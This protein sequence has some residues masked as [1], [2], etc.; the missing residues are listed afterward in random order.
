AMTRTLVMDNGAHAIKAGYADDS[1]S[2]RTI[3]NSI[4][5]GRGDRRSFVGD[6]LE[7]CK[8]YSGLYF[9]LP[10]ERGYLT[11]WDVE[12]DVW[13]RVFS[14]QVLKCVPS[15]V[16]LMITEPCFNPPNIQQTYDEMVFE[17]YGFE[18]YHRSIAP[19]LC[20][21]ANVSEENPPSECMIV[22][23]SGY[24]FTHIV[25]FC[26]GKPIQ[27]AIKRINLGGKLLTNHLKE[28]VS[29][30]Y[31]NMM[32]E[33]YLMNEIKEQC[34]YVTQNISVDFS[35]SK[36]QTPENSILQRYVLPDFSTK[37][38]KMQASQYDIRPH[39]QDSN[40]APLSED[41]QVL[42]MNNERFTIPEI[43]FHPSDIGI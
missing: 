22:V 8:D 28:V 18:A 40:D 37:K 39:N 6:Q 4:T 36:S 41:D 1:E 10:F 20:Q 25:P 30:R 12:K 43:L 23:D 34:C 26:E 5:A 7:D 24:S 11:N 15:E 3:P 9:R 13:D 27:S 42:N 38:Q 17:E 14:K 29:F 21:Y 16:S 32:D 2:G 33:T 35:I 31:W 19:K